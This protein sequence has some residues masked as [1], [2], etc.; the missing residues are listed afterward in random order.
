MLTAGYAGSDNM[1]SVSLIGVTFAENTQ[2]T[3]KVSGELTSLYTVK[4]NDGEGD[5][6]RFST[7]SLSRIQHPMHQHST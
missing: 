4:L 1:V 2:Y 7:G 3:L 5:S 6:Y